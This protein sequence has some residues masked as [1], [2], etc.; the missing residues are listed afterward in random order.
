MWYDRD[1][2]FSAVT[3]SQQGAVPVEEIYGE[4]VQ[5]APFAVVQLIRIP[6][7]EVA[8]RRFNILDR[9]QVRARAEMIKV[10]S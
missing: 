2:Q 5:L 1:P 4:R 7:L 3:L 9:E 10:V 6:V 8:V